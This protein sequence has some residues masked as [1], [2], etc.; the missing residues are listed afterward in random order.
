M[1][2]A[3]DYGSEGWGFDSL[4]ARW[5]ESA[6]LAGVIRSEDPAE[7]G[8]LGRFRPDVSQRCIRMEG[9]H[10]VEAHRPTDGPPAARQ[11][12]RARRRH[13]HR[14]RQAP[15]PPARHATRRSGRAQ[16]AAALVR[17]RRRATVGASEGTVGELVDAVGGEPG[18]RRRPRRRRSTSGRPATSARASARSVLDRLDPR[19]R[20]PLAR[21]HWPPAASYARRSIQIFRM[22]LRAALG[23]RRRRG[24]P[25]SQPGGTGRHAPPGR[26]A[27]PR[28]ARCR[29]GPRTRSHSSSPRSRTTAGTARSVSTC[30]TGCAAASCSACSWVDVDLKARHGPHRAGPDRGPRPPGRGPTARTPAPAARSRSTRRPPRQLAAHRRFQ[31]EERLAAGSQRGS[32]TTSSSRAGPARRSRRATSTRR[33]SGSSPRPAC[34]GSPRT[35]CATPRRPTWSATPTTS[36]RSA[37]PPTCSATARTC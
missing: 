31:A 3:S 33:S 17:R 20:R 23:R 2:R 22:V 34:R 18:R 7:G 6:G 24:P 14:D 36:A 30:S 11:V 28:C 27:R 10:G 8:V 21:R 29:R 32:T 9:R 26:Q 19:G 25:A 16:A 37:P 5:T 1:D 15:T 12:G 4:R 13:R 35:V